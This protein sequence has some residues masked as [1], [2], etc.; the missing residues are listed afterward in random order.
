M[1]TLSQARDASPVA[2]RDPNAAHEPEDWLCGIF[3][4]KT[5][6][7]IGASNDPVKVSGRPIDYLIRFGYPGRIIPVNPKRQQVQGLPC[8]PSLEAVDGQIDLALIL[9]DA[10]SSVAALQDCVNRGVRVAFL[11]AAGFAEIGGAGVARQRELEQ[12]IAASG[13]RVIGPNCTGLLGL[14]NRVMASFSTALDAEAIAE[15]P[16]R[17]GT[18][19]MVSQSGG[20]GGFLFSAAQQRGLGF[21]HYITTGNE[22]DLTLSE[23]LGLLAERDDVAT[24]LTYIENVSDGDR[25]VA[26]ARRARALGKPLVAVKAGRSE[27][28]AAAVRSHTGSLAGPGRV[29]DA[30]ARQHGVILADSLEQLTDIAVLLAP[31][32]RPRGRRLSIVSMSGGLGALSVDVAADAGLR[33]D[34]WSPEWSARMAEVIPSYGS[35]RNP[36]DVTATLISEPGLIERALQVAAEHPETDSVL[37][38]LGNTERGAEQIVES[39]VAAHDRMDL[40]MAVVWVGGSGKPRAMLADAGVPCFTDARQAVTALGILT[41]WSLQNDVPGPA[42]ADVDRARGR[43]VIETARRAGRRQLAEYESAQLLAAY[44]IESMPSEL[45]DTPQEC[46]AAAARLGGDVVVKIASADVAHKS[47]IGGV[48]VGP[49][50]EEEIAAAAR[51]VL[52]AGESVGAKDSRILVQAMAAPGLELVL[53]IQKDPVFGPMVVAGIGGTLVELLDDVQMAKAPIGIETATTMLQGLRAARVFD[54]LRGAGRYDLTAAAET[55]ARLSVLA[56]DFA[57]DIAEVDVNPLIVGAAGAVAVDG[58]VVLTDM[59]TTDDNE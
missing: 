38:L 43:A 45:V 57:D 34:A 24:L 59:E 33:V 56:H 26:A 52:A 14:E 41:D 4:P 32:R 28:G 7:I 15:Q 9:L 50:G 48:V 20:V 19:G 51:K 6:A 55:L 36:I 40:P 16:L 2:A 10:A 58:L 3:E 13:I 22:V 53:G 21:S 31:G 39:L 46:V 37:I 8:Y 54:G 35:A 27:L 25:F 18:T 5:I 11:A 47:D 29:F 23:V 49:V 44:G 17:S 1:T 30:V 42:P 12:I